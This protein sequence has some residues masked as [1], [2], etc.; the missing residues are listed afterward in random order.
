LLTNLFLIA[1]SDCQY[2]IQIQYS[3]DTVRIMLISLVLI[4][5]TRTYEY[6]TQQG[7]RM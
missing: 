6:A 5:Y 1:S 3:T 2:Q 7:F 4:S